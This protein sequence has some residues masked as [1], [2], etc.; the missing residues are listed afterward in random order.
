MPF[1]ERGW[2][3]GPLRY[4]ASER[5][6]EAGSCRNPSAPQ[7]NYSPIQNDM[8]ST[9]MVRKMFVRGE[10]KLPIVPRRNLRADDSL[11]CRMHDAGYTHTV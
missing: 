7:I 4:P 5:E 6:R 1:S 11:S 3:I 8:F 2:P 10:G 9:Q